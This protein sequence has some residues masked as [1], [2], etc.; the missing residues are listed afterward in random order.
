MGGKG[1]I[2]EIGGMEGLSGSIGGFQM[3]VVTGH[4][5]VLSSPRLTVQDSWDTSQET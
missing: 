4:G 2:E 5:D 3:R 1:D